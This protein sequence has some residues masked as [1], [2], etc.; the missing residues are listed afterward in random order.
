MKV[1]IL[2]SIEL[3]CRAGGGGGCRDSAAS[4]LV[5]A[6]QHQA[7][8]VSALSEAS[9][10]LTPGNSALHAK[11][12]TKALRLCLI[13]SR[14]QALLVAPS[15]PGGGVL[16]QLGR[17]CIFVAEIALER[18]LSTGRERLLLLIGRGLGRGSNLHLTCFTSPD[19]QKPGN[20]YI[21]GP[22]VRSFCCTEYGY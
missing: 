22:L 9:S 7:S 11:S 14:R 12:K 8:R 4:N 1:C 5:N 16:T 15:L 21:L 2:R 6:R 10:P 18:L 17:I 19:V 20:F 3:V 13:R